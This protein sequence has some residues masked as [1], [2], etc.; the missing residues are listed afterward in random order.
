MTRS[1]R[2]VLLCII[3]APLVAGG[4]GQSRGLVPVRGRVTFAGRNPPAVVSM[5]FVPND[6]PANLK[7][8][9]DQPRLGSAVTASDGS[10]VAGTSQAGDGLRPG[11]YEVRLVCQ[12]IPPAGVHS[13]S[14]RDFVPAEFSAPPLVVSREQG[15]I[16][17][18]V[19]VPTK[20]K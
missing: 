12:D 18:S 15:T 13:T 14:I 5:T 17:Y 9:G 4:C 1:R 8:S 11:T 10:F 20:P 7:D 19:D 16:E 3:G 6:M 2:L